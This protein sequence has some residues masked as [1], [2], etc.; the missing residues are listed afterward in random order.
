DALQYLYGTAKA[1]A[2]TLQSYSYKNGVLTQT[3]GGK[4]SKIAGSDVDDVIDAGSGNDIVGGF[5]G[6]DHL[7]GGAGNDILFGGLGDDI[8]DGGAGDDMLYGGTSRWS[9]TE[10]SDTVDYSWSTAPVLVKIEYSIYGDRDYNATGS[11]IGNDTL[12]S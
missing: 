1:P 9:G 5:A 10:G 6:N 11:S 4:S 7:K 2:G 12:Y 8:L 3:W